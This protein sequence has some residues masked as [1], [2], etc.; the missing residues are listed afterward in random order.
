[1]SAFLL[2]VSV[3]LAA[4]AFNPAQLAA[5]KTV[6]RALTNGTLAINTGDLCETSENATAQF[7]CN[8]A[9]NIESFSMY[10]RGLAGGSIPTEIGLLAKLLSLDVREA[11][12][13][14]TLPSQIGR[15][16]ALTLLLTA[17]NNLYGPVPTQLVP[18]AQQMVACTL[19]R[20]TN[21][22]N[23]F[24]CPTP[25]L[26]CTAT[27]ACNST[28]PGPTLAATTTTTP[29]TKQTT[30]TTTKA[31]TTQPETATTEITTV[32]TTTKTIPSDSSQV[33]HTTRVSQT[34][35][36]SETQTTTGEIT[37]PPAEP[38][39]Q[40]RT[41]LHPHASTTDE[42]TSQFEGNLITSTTNDVNVTVIVVVSCAAIIVVPL[43][44]VLLFLCL[45][46]RRREGGTKAANPQAESPRGVD[47][48]EPETE[49]NGFEAEGDRRVYVGG[50]YEVVPPN[51]LLP[52]PPGD[53]ASGGRALQQG[54]AF[55]VY[56]QAPPISQYGQFVPPAA[57]YEQ[58]HMPLVM[59]TRATTD[60][61]NE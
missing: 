17:G 59:G 26:V 36:A 15:C 56:D 27:L 55:R 42:K 57:R 22:G 50:I 24:T 2:F 53:Y 38:A 46:A 30:T 39:V 5:A 11:G 51:S 6:V 20:R 28:C 54:A 43:F 29:T 41:F 8:S 60:A 31:T 47:V 44:F 1:M 35:Q 48:S 9:G 10:K 16:T 23:C 52:P 40:M 14:G 12:L 13:T 34:T 33:S 32:E 4:V 37:L 21:E 7:T 18:L 49:S 58:P 25:T 19:M 61:K 45:S 3:A